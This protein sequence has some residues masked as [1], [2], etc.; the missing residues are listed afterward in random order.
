MDIR[1]EEI[2]RI[3]EEIRWISALKKKEFL[4]LGLKVFY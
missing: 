4:P 1:R 3:R 2:R